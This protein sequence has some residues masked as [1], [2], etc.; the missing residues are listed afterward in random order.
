M[1]ILPRLICLCWSIIFEHTCDHNTSPRVAAELFLAEQPPIIL[2]Y[3][4]TT[5]STK[6]TQTPRQFQESASRMH[7][8]HQC[9]QKTDS[10]AFKGLIKSVFQR[11]PQLTSETVF[12]ILMQCPNHMITPFEFTLHSQVFDFQK[13]SFTSCTFPLLSRNLV[14]SGLISDSEI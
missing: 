4:T 9:Q 12:Q 1:C 2:I 11:S 3:W 6:K 14:P 5:T 10:H 8:L 7:K 13:G